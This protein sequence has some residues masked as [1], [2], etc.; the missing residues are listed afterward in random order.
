MPSHD[1]ADRFYGLPITPRMLEASD[2]QLTGSYDGDLVNAHLAANY[3]C[4]GAIDKTLAGF[5]VLDDEGDNFTVL[6]VRGDGRVWWQDHETRELY[7][8]FDSLEDWVS[9]KKELADGTDEDELRDAYRTGRP[10]RQDAPGVPTT[11]TLA[12]RYQWL[13]WLLTQPLLD[14]EGK[15]VQSDEYLA[16]NA[17]GHLRAVW[18][19]DEDAQTALRA[20]LPHL[21][22]DPHLAVYWLLH[23]SLPALDEQRAQVLAAIGPEGGR[24]PLVEAF[25]AVFGAL[26][27]DGDVPVVPGFRARRSLALLEAATEPEQYARAA[28]VSLRMAPGV[29][30][31]NKFGFVCDGLADGTL[32][33]DAVAAAVEHMKPAPGTSALRALLDQRAGTARSRRTRPD[34]TPCDRDRRP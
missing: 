12:G 33:D 14:G 23:T 22:A 1:E 2:E 15:D 29:R 19:T 9:F 6:D 8:R 10:A 27:L 20:E 18:P 26:P 3:S 16:R 32:T 24:P 25:A 17:A 21:T 11:K 34:P 13:V 7:D 30:P 5:F 31:L 4:F 28:L